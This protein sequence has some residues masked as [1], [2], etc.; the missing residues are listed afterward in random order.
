MQELV[1][2]PW[3]F[4]FFQAVRLLHQVAFQSSSTTGTR[5]LR[6]VGGVWRPEDEVVQFHA[7]ISFGFPSAEISRAKVIGSGAFDDA[8]A[9]IQRFAVETTFMAIGGTSGVLPQ[10]YT[11]QI[12]DRERR[13]DFALRQFLDLFHHRIISLFYRAWE[14]YRFPIG[15]ERSQ[16]DPGQG[17]EDLFTQ[18]IYSLVGMGA[19]ALNPTRRVSSVVRNRQAFPDE[20]F[21]YYAGLFSHRP[22]TAVGL[23]RILADVFGVAVHVRQFQGQ[24]LKLD[25]HDQSQMPTA[26]RPLGLNC[27]LGSTAFVGERVWNVEGRIRIELGPLSYREFLRFSPGSKA[28]VQLAQLVRVWVGLEPDVEIQPILQ[29]EEVPMAAIGGS[30][31]A[32]QLGW[33]SWIRNQ[34][35]QNPADDAVFEVSDE[36]L[37]T[38]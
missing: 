11:R 3:K 7:Q 24:W 15:W 31:G 8:P 30:E 14:K 23:E 16:L 34:A 35:M 26:D 27:E 33:N 9:E 36:Y 12:L 29:S 28:F 37:V 5:P 10:H 4:D 6:S 19:D 17:T 13:N 25:L 18:A 20:T 21:L 32:S 38:S 1:E 22:R 2:E